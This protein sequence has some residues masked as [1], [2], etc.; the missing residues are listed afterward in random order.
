MAIGSTV[1]RSTNG[2]RPTW[3]RGI[4]AGALAA[5]PAGVLLAAV[6]PGDV[7][8][9]GVAG[10]AGTLAGWLAVLALGAAGGAVFGVLVERAAGYADAPRGR[11]LLGIAY[12][13][14][15]WFLLEHALPLAAAATGSGAP[16]RPRLNAFPLAVLLVYVV[17]LA[18]ATP[19]SG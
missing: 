12:G 10:P 3:R 7:A 17:V 8:V 11:A 6:A 4:L 19:S 13:T 1:A 15:L 5:I 14:A 18:L 16:G 9:P 2:R